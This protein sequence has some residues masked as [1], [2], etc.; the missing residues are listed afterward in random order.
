[1]STTHK[2]ILIGLIGLLAAAMG[3]AKGVKVERDDPF[4]ISKKE[5]YRRVDVVALI[6]VAMPDGLPDPDPIR[7]WFLSQTE[8]RFRRA[9]FSVLKPQDYEHVWTRIVDEM[10]GLADPVTG[11]R[12]V[13]RTLTAMLRTFEEIDTPFDID[14]VAV[15]SIVVVE[16][17][18]ASGRAEWDG[19]SQSIKAGGVVEDFFAGSPD[20]TLDALSF[21]VDI[22]DPAGAPLYSGAG[23]IEVLRKLAGREFVLVPRQELFKDDGRNE[24]AVKL[25]LDPLL[26]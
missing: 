9:G 25:A 23:G 21:V 20:G 3:C 1:M 4:V 18:F 2:I 14:A 8:Y 22:V 13:S 6:D 19:A 24:K 16:A 15:P 10:G 7:R 26:D 17:R 12:D 5:F 11:R